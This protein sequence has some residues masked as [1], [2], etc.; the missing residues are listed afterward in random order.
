[1]T[2]RIVKLT[3]RVR[4]LAAD[5]DCLFEERVMDNLNALEAGKSHEVHE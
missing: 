4:N 1:M 3:H 5:I 2:Y